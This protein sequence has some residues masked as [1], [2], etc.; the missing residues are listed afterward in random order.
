VVSTNTEG[1]TTK[2]TECLHTCDQ[3]PS[4][5]KI[6]VN[7]EEKPEDDGKTWIED[8][9]FEMKWRKLRRRRPQGK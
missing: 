9:V 1:E 7:Q 4:V 8:I 3:A 6:V 5:V 2:T